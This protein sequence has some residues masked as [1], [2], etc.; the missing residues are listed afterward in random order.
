MRIKSIMLIE[1]ESRVN[2]GNVLHVAHA[3]ENGQRPTKYWPNEL[4][5]ITNYRLHT[6]T[7]RT[8]SFLKHYRLS[9]HGLDFCGRLNV[10]C[11]LMCVHTFY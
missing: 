5:V 8:I 9:H 1:D 6:V 10:N 2:F 3:S 4:H 7:Y 11:N